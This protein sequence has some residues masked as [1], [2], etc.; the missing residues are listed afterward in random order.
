M[1][2]LC[3]SI[4]VCNVSCGCHTTTFRIKRHILL[5][6]KWPLQLG[7]CPF[8]LTHNTLPPRPIAIELGMLLCLML[9]AARRKKKIGPKNGGNNSIIM[10]NFMS[11][12]CHE[13]MILVPNVQV[14]SSGSCCKKWPSFDLFFANLSNFALDKSL[15]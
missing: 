15:I 2:L 4:M 8:E 1:F 5:E 10:E 6:D 12:K 13:K 3:A 7:D 11:T 9:Y 14:K